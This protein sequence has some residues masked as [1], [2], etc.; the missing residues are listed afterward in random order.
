MIPLCLCLESRLFAQSP[1][2]YPNLQYDHVYYVDCNAWEDP[3][4]YGSG[5]LDDPFTTLTHAMAVAKEEAGTT[6]LIL[7]GGEYMEQYLVPEGGINAGW[8]ENYPI[9]WAS[10]VTIQA[11]ITS[12]NPLTFEEVVLTTEGND[13][14]DILK[15][16][17]HNSSFKDN[18][19]RYFGGWT[20]DA[21]PAYTQIIG[22]TFRTKHSGN[23]DTGSG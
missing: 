17:H 23:M 7:R 2:Y 6:L 19:A 11:Y 16:L 14:Q 20:E 3:D 18:G 21:D 5:T 13:N 8:P 4:D 1:Q 10:N 12:T 22:V 9:S 15:V